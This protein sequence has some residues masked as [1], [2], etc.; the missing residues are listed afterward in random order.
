MVLF[1]EGVSQIPDT[2]DILLDWG[3]DGI[4]G[5]GDA[6]EIT[7]NWMKVS[8]WM[9]KRSVIFANHNGEFI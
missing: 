2:R 1:H 8:A 9:Q 4:P 7:V 3:L 5:T 6:G